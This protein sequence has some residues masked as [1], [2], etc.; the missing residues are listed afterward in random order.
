MK[1]CRKLVSDKQDPT[2]EFNQGFLNKKTKQRDD[3]VRKDQGFMGSR[4]ACKHEWDIEGDE[5]K[6]VWIVSGL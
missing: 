5:S 6:S 2:R 3:I 4:T 1:K